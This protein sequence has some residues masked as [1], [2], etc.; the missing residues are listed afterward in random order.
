MDERIV[1]LGHTGEPIKCTEDEYRNGLRTQIQEA[2]SKWID[3]GQDIR[4]Q[5]ALIEVRR[6]DTKFPSA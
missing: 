1:R 2:A 6:L 3:N 5:M 4:A